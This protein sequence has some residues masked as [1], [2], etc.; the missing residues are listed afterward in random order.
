MTDH[1][2]ICSWCFLPLPGGADF[3]C[4]DCQEKEAM[5]KEGL[6]TAPELLKR[7]DFERFL[8][9]LA[10]YAIQAMDSK[11]SRKRWTIEH[12]RNSLALPIVNALPMNYISVMEMKPHE[13]GEPAREVIY[14]MKAPIPKT[15][16]FKTLE[17]LKIWRPIEK[18][19]PDDFTGA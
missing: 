9:K 14:T 15:V 17:R 13:P 12:I 2:R 5:L 6:T 18:D 11:T 19:E 10:V 1:K 7:E 8:W 16:L 4:L 3:L